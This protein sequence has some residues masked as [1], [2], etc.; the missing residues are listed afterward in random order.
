M[1]IAVFSSLLQTVFY[2]CTVI[3]DFFHVLKHETMGLLFIILA[4][5][6]TQI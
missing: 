4:V 6:M 2:T 5:F 1:L 3:D